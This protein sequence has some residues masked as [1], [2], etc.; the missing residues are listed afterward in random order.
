LQPYSCIFNQ[1]TIVMQDHIIKEYLFVAPIDKV[2]SAI[3]K[4]EEISSWFIDADFKPEKGYQYTFNSKGENCSV[5][6]GEVREASP[7]RLVYTWIVK[8]APIE[9]VVSWQLSQVTGGTKL[10]LEHSGISNYAGETA[11]EMFNS[12]NGGWTNCVDKLTTYLKQL[13]YAG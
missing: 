5:I 13:T 2:W 10:V 11:I 4:A 3:T 1:K 7:Y 9:T 12:F 6:S 8:D